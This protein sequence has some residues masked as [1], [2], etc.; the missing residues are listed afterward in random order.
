MAEGRQG[1]QII[2]HRGASREAPENSRAAFDA[3]L[4]HAVSGIEFDV[5]L[6]LDG[7]PVLYHD[8]TLSRIGGGRRRISDF[9]LKE[10]RALDWGSWFDS[11]FAGEPLMTLDG[12]LR[13]YGRRTILFLEI[14][15]RRLD[16]LSG[17]SEILTAKV[18]SAVRR[19]LPK[20][21]LEEVCLLSFDPGV[22]MLAAKR[23]P[24]WNYVLNIESPGDWSRA[25]R[26]RGVPLRACCLPVARL[27]PA[28]ARRLHREGLQVMTYSCNTP[29]QALAA[30]RAGADTILTDDPRWLGTY[31][32][33]KAGS[34]AT[35]L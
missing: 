2:A 11:S 29:R 7:V 16:R 33:G 3:A 13:R 19:I 9:R 8:R 35:G 21:R 34:S 15:S 4:R 26:P 14:K 17:R 6:T 24:G 32:A 5:Q 18:L 12:V 25:N 20:E 28:F 22:L 1:T 31:L 10:L 27:T 23:E 30:L